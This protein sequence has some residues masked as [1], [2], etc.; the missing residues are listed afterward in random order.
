MT[1]MMNTTGRDNKMYFITEGYNLDSQNDKIREQRSA[2]TLAFSNSNS[3]F[4]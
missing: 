3:P 1:T 4:Y 2:T